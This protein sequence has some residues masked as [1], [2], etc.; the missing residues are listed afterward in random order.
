MATVG[1]KAVECAPFCDG[2]T[3]AEATTDLYYPFT[4]ALDSSRPINSTLSAIKAKLALAI[5]SKGE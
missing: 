3:V 1:A 2:K 4:D 5:V